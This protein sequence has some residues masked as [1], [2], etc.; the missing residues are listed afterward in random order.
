MVAAPIVTALTHRF[1]K[2][3]TMSIGIVL[4]TSGYVAAGFT[5]RIWQLMVTLGILVG[6]GIGFVYVPSLP[7]LSQWFEALR[8]SL[9]T[10]LQVRAPGLGRPCLLGRP[11]PLSTHSGYA[12]LYASQ[13]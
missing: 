4:Q 6:H 7:I 12:G 8:H 5:D 9:V 2:A 13:D 11:G 10:G 3:V 1:G